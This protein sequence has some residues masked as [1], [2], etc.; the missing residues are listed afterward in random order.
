MPN[1]KQSMK[2]GD[3]SKN[4]QAG[5]DITI[6]QGMSYSEVKEI[7]M[8]VFDKNFYDLG[9]QVNEIAKERAEKV[10]RDYLDQLK[11]YDQSVLE[12][13]TDPDIRANLY[14][15][16][17]NYARRGDENIGNL[18]STMLVE[19]TVNN[20]DD[21]K[22][23]V[24]NQA[25]DTVNKLTVEQI[26]FLSLLFITYYLN[27]NVDVSVLNYI[28][29]YMPFYYLYNVEN[30]ILKNRDIDYL[31][32][33]GCVDISIGSRDIKSILKSK[34]I[35]EFKGEEFDKKIDNFHIFSDLITTWDSE[36]LKMKNSTI[37]PVGMMIAIIN[38]NNK[39][40]S[41]EIK[42]F[43]LIPYDIFF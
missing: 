17:K 36:A 40:E 42:S 12:K 28:D 2:S 25:L 18:L 37:L 16:Q 4:Y 19:R 22:N 34:N 10:V 32:S 1:N 3:D 35:L 20:N 14:E 29:L 7:S 21:Y 11:V 26:D 15:A 8:D 24:L 39:V 27:L 5:N 43:A 23:I 31:S 9:E 41:N 6:H 38:I 30:T 13:T 33:V